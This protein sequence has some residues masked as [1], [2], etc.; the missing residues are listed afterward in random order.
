MKT[1][2]EIAREA[3]VNAVTI[4]NQW[5]WGNDFYLSLGWS[6][7]NEP[8]FKSAPLTAG[9]VEK[10]GLRVQDYLTKLIIGCIEQALTQCPVPPGVSE[11]RL[12]QIWHLTDIV[13]LV[14]SGRA[15][16]ILAHNHGAAS[17]AKMVL[18][19]KDHIDHLHRIMHT[20]ESQAIAEA[21]DQG[22]RDQHRSDVEAA[23]AS[24][25]WD[26]SYP[27]NAVIANAQGK[28]S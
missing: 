27:I 24:E 21:Y 15:Q 25:S 11:E 17:L 16:D 6:D 20:P 7:V 3:A 19:L 23:E 13:P 8:V 10:D 28:K 18:D 22:R 14:S 5:D 12:E 2:E 1:P 4:H 26:V 9:E